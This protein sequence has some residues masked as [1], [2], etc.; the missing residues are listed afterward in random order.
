[1]ESIEEFVQ[2]L[3]KQGDYNCSCHINPPC[4]FCTEDLGDLYE[5]HLRENEQE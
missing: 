1:M 5:E 2:L 4:A 3:I